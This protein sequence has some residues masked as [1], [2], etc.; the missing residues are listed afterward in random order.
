MSRARRGLSEWIWRYLSNEAWMGHEVCLTRN[1]LVYHILFR[2]RRHNTMLSIQVFAFGCTHLGGDLASASCFRYTKLPK[3][4]KNCRNTVK[5][6][7]TL[8]MFGR[9]RSLESTFNGCMKEKGRTL[10]I[11][12]LAKYEV[13]L[14]QDDPFGWNLAQ[15]CG[16]LHW[17]Q[18]FA[19]NKSMTEQP[20]EQRWG[21]QIQAISAPQRDSVTANKENTNLGPRYEKETSS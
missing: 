10:N 14:K 2:Q 5:I 8:N 15:M 9:G 18:C 20:S 1:A 12:I 6:V 21:Q 4:T 7:Y 17:K 19:Q 11:V 16:L 13:S 3:C